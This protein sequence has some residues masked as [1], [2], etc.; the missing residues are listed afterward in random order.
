MNTIQPTFVG[1]GPSCA[2]PN[3]NDKT[4]LQE[5]MTNLYKENVK[6]WLNEGEDS[7]DA[8]DQLVESYDTDGYAFARNLEKDHYWECNSTLVDI[9]D[10]AYY[11]VKRVHDEKVKKWYRD[12]HFELYPI[13]TTAKIIGPKYSSLIGKSVTI[14]SH[15]AEVARYGCKEKDQK[16]SWIVNHEDL[17]VNV[18]EHS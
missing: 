1:I 4:I 8:I 6:S 10:G 15:Y 18:N 13:G 5:A 11:T 7:E 2:R 3:A 9:L 16:G 17:E 12:N 14:D